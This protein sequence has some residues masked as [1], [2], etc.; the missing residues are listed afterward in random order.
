MQGCLCQS[1]VVV[2]LDHWG[3]PEEALVSTKGPQYF[4]PRPPHHALQHRLGKCL[5]QVN[6]SAGQAVTDHTNDR[7]NERQSQTICRG[8]LLQATVR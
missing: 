5:P 1:L 6:V 3:R 7:F 8:E 2:A 4:W